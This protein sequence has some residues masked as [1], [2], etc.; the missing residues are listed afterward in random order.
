MTFF[1]I[2]NTATVTFTSGDGKPLASTAE[3]T[4]E[5]M[6]NS[7]QAGSDYRKREPESERAPASFH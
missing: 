2:F 5:V 7:V 1:D 6:E 3:C 4:V